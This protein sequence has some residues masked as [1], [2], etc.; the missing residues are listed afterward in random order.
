MTNFYWEKTPHVCGYCGS[1][2]WHANAFYSNQ[3][4]WLMGSEAGDYDFYC[5]DCDKQNWIVPAA[6]FHGEENI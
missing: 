4:G 3:Q 6:D 1:D 2:E 5:V